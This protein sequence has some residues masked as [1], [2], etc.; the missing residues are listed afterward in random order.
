MVSVAAYIALL[1]YV[2]GRTFVLSAEI[3]GGGDAE[4][5]D[6]ALVRAD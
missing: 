1:V 4:I 3:A 2:G 6:V 5:D